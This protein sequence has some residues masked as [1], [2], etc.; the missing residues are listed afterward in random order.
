[1]SGKIE[2]KK[3][4]DS[5]HRKYTHLVS[6]DKTMNL[7]MGDSI[8]E[9]SGRFEI[10]HREG[11]SKFGEQVLFEFVINKKINEYKNNS[12]NNINYVEIYFSKE[13]IKELLS[14]ASK[15]INDGNIPKK[16]DGNQDEKQTTS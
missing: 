9:F 8:K 4:I 15:M 5:N 14:N 7:R 1:M 11:E 13:E 16:E 10:V 2:V 6:N 12:N 3:F